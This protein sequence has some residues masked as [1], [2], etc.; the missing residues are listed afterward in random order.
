MKNI[1]RKIEEFYTFCL[2]VLTMEMTYNYIVRLLVEYIGFPGTISDI[3]KSSASNVLWIH[4][5]CVHQSIEELS[6]DLPRRDKNILLFPVIAK[7]E[8]I[9]IRVNSN[10]IIL[11]NPVSV[12]KY[13]EFQLQ[14]LKTHIY[15]KL[16]TSQSVF[17]E[18]AL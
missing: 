18:K 16:S 17:L 6:W 2:R 4:H 7:Y 9:L 8:A 5:K 1:L 3:F 12:G 11:C 10:I 14:G 13:N 15:L